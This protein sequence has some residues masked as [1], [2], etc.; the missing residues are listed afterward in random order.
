MQ[1]GAQSYE[2]AVK[3]FI[4]RL[5]L[6]LRI[7]KS[8]KEIFVTFYYCKTNKIIV[9]DSVYATDVIFIFCHLHNNYVALHS[10]FSPYL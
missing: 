10:I 9:Y 7:F 2:G 8:I 6:S 3:F 1:V 4:T 5:N